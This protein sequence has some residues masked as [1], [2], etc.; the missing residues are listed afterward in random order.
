MSWID[1]ATKKYSC[2]RR[3]SRPAS[4][5]S[6]GYNTQEMFSYSFL[7]PAARA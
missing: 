3:N 5:L 7:A 6:L 2:F 4:V 1:A